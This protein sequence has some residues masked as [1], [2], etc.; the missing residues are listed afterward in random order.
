MSNRA[1]PPRAEEQAETERLPTAEERFRGG[2]LDLADLM[3]MAP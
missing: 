1:S 3:G 2:L